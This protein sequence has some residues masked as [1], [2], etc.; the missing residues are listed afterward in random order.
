MRGLKGIFKGF[1]FNFHIILSAIAWFLI[2]FL[3]PY[4]IHVYNL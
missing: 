1:F 2:T 3:K 4:F